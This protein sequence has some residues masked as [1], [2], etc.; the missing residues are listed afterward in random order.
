[1]SKENEHIVVSC[2]AD[3]LFLDQS[4][5]YEWGDYGCTASSEVSSEM[6]SEQIERGVNWKCPLTKKS[7]TVSFKESK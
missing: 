6:K 2:C 7:I 1:M 5:T 3:C 4:Y